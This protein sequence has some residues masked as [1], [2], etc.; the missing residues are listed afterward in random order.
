MNI[1]ANKTLSSN[2]LKS[3]LSEEVISNNSSKID[4]FLIK[5]VSRC[6]LNCDYCYV[7][8]HADQSWRRLP[9]VLSFEKREL[10]A[11]RISE[12]ARREKL[13]RCLIIF[14]GGEPL[15]AGAERILETINLIKSEMSPQTEVS[16]SMQTNGVLLTKSMLDN[17]AKENVGVSLSLDGPQIAN[18][19]HRLTHK[20]NS[21]FP[22]VIKAFHLLKEYPQIFIGVLSVI[23]T[24]IPP[25]DILDFF[26][27]LKPPQLDLLLPDANYTQPPPLRD[28][29]PDVYVNW[30]IDAFDIWYDQY[31]ELNIRFFDSLVGAI[32]GLPSE[33]DAF[34]LGE[35][36]LLSIETD[37]T[38][39]G[40]DVLKITKE[41]YSSLDMNI[42]TH[43][44]YE[45]A[46]SPKINLHSYLVSY[47]GLSNA[48]KSCPE[49]KVCGGGAVPHR[50]SEEGFDNPTVYCRE[51]LSLITHARKKLIESVRIESNL[52]F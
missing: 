3:H 8:Q 42:Q 15:L 27:E 16:F 40:L 21:S 33:T 36:S 13:E 39:H 31:P 20:K 18:D 28:A 19:L 38:Y 5:I 32:I 52:T 24:R 30:L 43:S 37:G 29:N 46:N 2:L 25:H 9:V 35:V 50:Y 22:A 48:C 14:H 12:H 4:T 34:G 11:K 17:F 26:A 6:N 23:D 10:L 44:I 7:F 41:G 1:S 45:A 51:M 47:E 49:V